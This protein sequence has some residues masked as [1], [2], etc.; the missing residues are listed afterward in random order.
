M[1]DLEQAITE[2][3]KAMR[4]SPSIEDGDVEELERYLRDKVD[5]LAAH[6]AS[7]E[8]AFRS[9]EA[10][11]RQAGT[12]EAAYGHARS[13]RPSGRFPWRAP[14]FTPG[15]F[16]SYVKI[17]LRR[18]RLQ[19][20]HSL[21]NIGG[22]ALGIAACLLVYL[23]VQDEVGYD[24]FHERAAFID[25]VYNTADR[26]DGSQNVHMGSF[27][28]LAAA[29]KAQCPEVV[30]AARVQIENGLVIRAEDRIFNNDFIALA[31]PALFKIFTFPFLRGNPG[32]ALADKF[33]V[34][35][36]ERM[37]R[38]YFGDRDPVG[39]TLRVNGQFDVQVSAVIKD[40]PAQS[41]LRFDAIVPFVLQF[42]PSFQE[43]AHWGGN[44][45]E[46]WVLLSPGADR[47]AIE[48]KITGI[49]APAFKDQSI[50]IAFHLHP[51]LQKRLYSPE[52]YGLVRMIFLFSAAALFVLTLA[53]VNFMNL[54]TARAATRAKEI[55]VRKT[56]GAR[57]SDIVRQ[58]LGES[59]GTAFLALGA[60]LVLV[61]LILPVFDRIAGKD[62][63]FG[64]VLRASS[65]LGFLVITT[66]AGL[67][68]GIYPAF[69][70]SSFRPRAVLAGREGGRLRHSTGLRKG[71][72]VFQFA[73][74]FVLVVGTAV[75]GRQIAFVK[76]KDLGFDRQNLVVIRL[77][78]A[79][80][81]GFDAFKNELLATAG[82]ERVTA[83]LQNPINIGSTVYGQGI[84]WT[85]KDP[86]RNV[87]LN[88]DWVDYDYFETLKTSFVTGRPFSKDFPS[89]AQ[90]AFVINEAA[91]TLMG[92]RD[93]VGQ[94]MRVFEREGTIVGV[95]KD[96]HFRP[97]RVAIEPIVFGLRP[98]A[99][100]WA[101]VRI[102]PGTTAKSLGAIAAAVKRIDPDS[103]SQS[104]FF[105][106]LMIRSQYSIEQKIWNVSNYLSLAAVFIACIGLFGLASFLTQQ[107]TKEI[108]VRKV[109]GASAPGLT[110]KLAREFLIWVTL[111]VV[112][113][114]P[115]AYWASRKILEN[116][117]Y[118]APLGAGLYVLAGLAMLAIAALTVGSQ[119]LRAARANP[120]YSLRYE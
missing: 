82:I 11:F 105:D 97:L 8:E 99:R 114:C 94:R 56:V 106:D 86:A 57:K 61:A 66:F 77:G 93:P 110:M 102:S 52:G 16:R 69:A 24:R 115:A 14:L 6:G 37:A 63:S 31:D 88:W 72:V 103:V 22:L 53:C 104:D 2:W 3:K 81:E 46:T 68:A 28:P 78:P 4:R 73:L 60:A 48:A 12:L 84:D 100:S 118:R 95:V 32:T 59:L 23:W 116:Y 35:L 49:A 89:D 117:A 91:A 87:T 43:P 64:V 79:L 108:G 5:D 71:L 47:A 98:S 34:V 51:L 27:Y 45:F 10:E 85:G 25:Q 36:T 9:A 74:S 20:A 90:G 19:K 1:F 76:S 44:P 92:L 29:L 112:L 58:F 107:R 70:L 41:S 55:G 50:R 40:I 38:K 83:G 54:S 111:A 15:L 119:T 96:F 67:A 21:I 42:A 65:I 17:A 30:E 39:R 33:A 75:V 80:A 120:V 62:L 26:G 13:A 7:P 109:M 113:A 101:F 18:L